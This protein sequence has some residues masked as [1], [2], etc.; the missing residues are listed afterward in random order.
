[1]AKKRS[2]LGASGLEVIL[3]S[4]DSKVEQVLEGHAVLDTKLEKF[5]HELK[6]EIHDLKLGQKDILAY[7]SRID[8]EIQEIKQ[9][10][11]QK[12]DLERLERLEK[13]VA[14]IKLAMQKW[15]K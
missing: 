4:I 8:E 9:V 6:S 1:M 7:L 5:H 10:L 2:E 15:Q 13:E 14:V 12:A 11:R 3:E